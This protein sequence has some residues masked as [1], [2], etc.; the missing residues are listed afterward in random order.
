MFFIFIIYFTMENP[1]TK[2]EIFK[3]IGWSTAIGVWGL[4]NFAAL[5]AIGYGIYKH[6]HKLI[7]PDTRVYFKNIKNKN[8]KN[9]PVTKVRKPEENECGGGGFFDYLNDLFFPDT[10]IEIQKPQKGNFYIDSLYSTN[11]YLQK[12]FVNSGG[13]DILFENEEVVAFCVGYTNTGITFIWDE[14]K[15]K[16]LLASIQLRWSKQQNADNV[17]FNKN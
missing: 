7:N 8:L 2:K 16:N 10:V 14:K 1:N 5:P 9:L 13:L 17:V 11:P 6:D 12:K 4:V 15:I 3:K